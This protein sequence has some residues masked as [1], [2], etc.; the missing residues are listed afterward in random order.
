MTETRKAAATESGSVAT[1]STK[2]TAEQLRSWEGESLTDT[3][4]V[5]LGLMTPDEVSGRKRKRAPA[6]QKLSDRAAI[7]AEI[8][9]VVRD[10]RSGALDPKLARLLL[11]GFQ[12]ALS[13]LP[14]AP[15]NPPGR[16]RTRPPSPPQKK[17]SRK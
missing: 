6:T 12:C 13:A 3:L 16:P 9:A 8:A 14:K 10:L 5:R 11:Y 2:Y 15:K 7:Q 17:A 1:V 4:L